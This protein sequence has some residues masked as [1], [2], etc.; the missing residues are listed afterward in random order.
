[1]ALFERVQSMPL[2]KAGRFGNVRRSD[3]LAFTRSIPAAHVDDADV[4]AAK[5]N[6]S[7]GDHQV[8][9]TVAFL[10]KAAGLPRAMAVDANTA[11]GIAKS[12][13]AAKNGAA[14]VPTYIQ[15]LADMTIGSE[16]P[17]AGEVTSRQVIKHVAGQL[18]GRKS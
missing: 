11:Y 4:L 14:Y 17:D 3:V 15:H 10:L 18:K 8:R 16:V 2:W 7:F 6:E 12:I 13:L 1:M 5:L 9:Q